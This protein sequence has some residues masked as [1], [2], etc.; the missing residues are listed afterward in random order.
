MCRT[1][2]LYCIFSGYTVSSIIHKLFKYLTPNSKHCEIPCN[3]KNVSSEVYT[4]AMLS[5]SMSVYKCTFPIK[6]FVMQT[7]LLL[8]LIWSWYSWRDQIIEFFST[9]LFLVPFKKFHYQR[10]LI[11]KDWSRDSYVSTQ[12]LGKKRHN[13]EYFKA[14]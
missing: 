6:D 11:S 3:L 14:M 7:W 13:S 2:Y 5:L 4:K 10:M 8:Y 12:L 1:L 9:L